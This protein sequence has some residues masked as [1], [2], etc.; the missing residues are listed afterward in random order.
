M[1]D[2]KNILYPK[3]SD[4]IQRSIYISEIKN[5]ASKNEN[6]ESAFKKLVGKNT[7]NNENNKSNNFFIDLKDCLNSEG[8]NLNTSI[9]QYNELIKSMNE[10]KKN[11]SNAG[12]KINCSIKFKNKST[13]KLFN[14]PYERE[15]IF[16]LKDINEILSKKIRKKIR[17]KVKLQKKL[18]KIKHSFELEQQENNKNLIEL[19]SN[20]IAKKLDPKNPDKLQN[21]LCQELIDVPIPLSSNKKEFLQLLDSSSSEEYVQKKF[22]INSL[23]T[24]SSS[25]EI[26]SCYKNINLMTNGEMIKNSRFK[27]F[28]E[29]LI[30]RN[31]KKKFYVSEKF[32]ST[33]SRASD[34]FKKNNKKKG[35]IIL[36]NQTDKLKISTFNKKINLTKRNKSTTYVDMENYNFCD[37]KKIAMIINL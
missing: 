8:N 29:N 13:R 22:N 14:Y 21:N 2:N 1:K 36:K 6:I 34:K 32:K 25:F 5:K 4:E 16:T 31:S 24:T 37:S 20:I 15:K 18:E 12:S 27:R 19:Y 26:K 33:I 7:I 17:K 23:K 9:T 30:K 10:S 35:E 11:D 3:E 28:I